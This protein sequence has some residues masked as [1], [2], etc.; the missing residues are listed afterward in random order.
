MLEE[1]AAAE[2]RLNQSRNK[3]LRFNCKFH[4]VDVE[5][6]HTEHLRRVLADRGYD[7]DGQ[8]IIVYD[9]RFQDVAD[10]IIADVL[11]RQPIAGRAIV[12][13]DQCGFSRVSMSLVARILRM[14][15]TAEVILTFAADALVNHLADTPAFAQA[16]APIDL[17]VAQIHELIALKDGDGGRALVQ[18]VLRQHIR[19]S[20]GAAFDTPFYIRPEPSR[21]ALWFLHLSKHP[22]ARDV[23][24]QCHWSSFNTFEHYGTG[25]FNMLGWDA[26]NTGTLPMFHFEDLEAEQMREQL[27]NSMPDE[28]YA[29]AAEEPVTVDTMRHMLANR[30]AA[31]FS[32]LDAT[33]LRL[34]AERE[35][36][37][38]T[39]ED[40][41]RSRSIARLNPT[42]RIA[43]PTMRLFPEFSR[44]SQP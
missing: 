16:V 18:R 27:L 6:D 7:V 5:L 35:V 32:D 43:I 12:L 14:L 20:T 42:D 22:I 17:T 4:F 34:A 29:L 8:K 33:V 1:A 23:M 25:D 36:D 11:G 13:L 3:P 37:I 19:S 44:L 21:R 31:R 26:L 28:L 24:I 30:T 40:R 2:E 38:L 9:G 15:P 39:A 41:E 10:S